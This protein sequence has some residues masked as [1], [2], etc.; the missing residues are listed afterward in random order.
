MNFTSMKKT[1]CFRN[2]QRLGLML[3]LGVAVLVVFS[4]GGFAADSESTGHFKMYSTVEYTGK[5]QFKNQI[6]SLFTVRKELLSDSKVQYFVSSRDFD[7]LRGDEPSS[8]EI[9]FIVDQRTKR[10]SGGGRDL[11]LFERVSNH[12]IGALEKVT[13]D[14]VGKTWKQSFD[15]SSVG[16]LLP[17]DLKLT[18]TAIEQQ[19]EAQ[20]KLIAVRALSEP[21]K[22]RALG[23]KGKA[24]NVKC[25]VN[26][27]Y[28][29]DEHIEEIFMSMSVFEAK[30]NING[31]NEKLRHEIATYKTNS[32]GAPAISGKLGKKFEKL[33]RGV[34][35]AKKALKVSKEVPLPKWAKSEGLGTSHVANMCAAR[36]CEGALNPVAVVLVSG[37][38]VIS[39]QT[40]GMLSS[41]GA[42]AAASGTMGS[43]SGSLAAGVPALGGMNLA[44]APTIMGVGAGTAGAIAGGTTAIAAGTSGGGSSSRSP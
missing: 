33:V 37:S 42:M 10:L 31:F 7:L 27:L 12:C 20:G 29:F 3:T 21:F 35:L 34:G 32:K 22:V 1:G 6:E 18:L 40:M 25:R 8:S 36:A 13:K 15:L 14:N 38:R 4:P 2:L 23:K 17:A 28:L 30:T 43:I 24:G 26:S 16:E 5:G 9:S 19:T 11:A 41:T 39:M 44:A